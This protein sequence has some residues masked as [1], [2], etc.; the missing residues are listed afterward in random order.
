M[1]ATLLRA[2]VVAGI[3][4]LCGPGI[5][6]ADDP[7]S[8]ENSPKQGKENKGG[9]GKGFGKG[10]H[11]DAFAKAFDA[12][13]DGKVSKEEFLGKRP[14]FDKMDSNHDG[15]VTKEE[16]AALPA[17]QKKGGTG[18]GFVANFDADADGKVTP[19]EYDAKRTKFF[20]R[21]DKNK[22]GVIEKSELKSTPPDSGL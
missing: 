2:G 9:K 7:G 11:W 14:G 4:A 19:A 10:Q 21:M 16:V 12:N 13:T 22:D 6:R 18:G 5:V 15:S 8:P 1:R 17:V 20:D 3:L